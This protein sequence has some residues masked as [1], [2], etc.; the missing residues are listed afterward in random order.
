MAQPLPRAG[1]PIVDTYGAELTVTAKSRSMSLGLIPATA[2]VVRWGPAAGVFCE[3][4][5]PAGAILNLDF[6]GIIHEDGL[7]FT[8]RTATGAGAAILGIVEM[9]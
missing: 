4:A 1:L 8:V 7:T 9:I 6:G 5:R 2:Y 3:W